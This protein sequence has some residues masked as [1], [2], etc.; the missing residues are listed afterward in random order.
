[1]RSGADLPV[2]NLSRWT[3]VKAPPSDGH[4]DEKQKFL[5]TFLIGMG[6]YQRPFS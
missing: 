1:M 5:H 6:F 3:G 2:G 4:D